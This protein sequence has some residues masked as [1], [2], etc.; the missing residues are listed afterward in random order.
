MINSHN[1]PNKLVRMMCNFYF[2]FL[3]MWY[4]HDD[5]F[6]LFWR[7]DSDCDTAYKFC[8]ER[9]AQLATVTEINKVQALCQNSF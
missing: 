2:F 8:N 5:V 6:Y 3:E 4:L 9:E 1:L 7:N